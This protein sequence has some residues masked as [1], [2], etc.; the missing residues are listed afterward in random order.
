MKI[1]TRRYHIY[2]WARV[3][4]FIIKFVPLK[5]AL[6]LAAFGGSLAY[7]VLPKYRNTAINNL[8]DV[9]GES[10]RNND[11]ARRVFINLAKNGAEW[12]KLATSD[13]SLVKKLVTDSEGFERLDRVL[14][15]GNGA[16][17]IAGHFGN[18]ELLMAYVRSRGYNGAVIGKRIYFH[19]YNE[20]ITNLRLK[21][22]DRVIYRDE[23]PKKILRV[24]RSGEIIGI[25]ADQ[26]IDSLEGVF[27]EFLGKKAYTSTAP[28]RLSAASGAAILPAFIIRGKDDKHKLVFDEP[29]EIPQG[30]MSEEE[31]IKYTSKWTKVLEKYVTQ[32][33]DHWVWIH[34]R[35]KTQEDKIK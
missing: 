18:W 6:A 30:K 12:I 29:I 7:S 4:F 13:N 1:K 9:F 2:Y 28:V 25:L 11:I 14:A 8:N 10:P 22:G 21:T 19:K 3:L 32:Y 15:K 31:A 24:L 17:V 5:A 26:D 27:V 20:F 23:S 35:W 33:P 16:L 34:K